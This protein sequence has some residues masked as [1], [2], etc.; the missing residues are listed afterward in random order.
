MVLMQD[1]DN[2]LMR[3]GKNVVKA[4]GAVIDGVE[5]LV[6]ETA[7]QIEQSVA[8]VRESIIKRYPTLFLLAVTFGATATVTG[9]EQ[10]LIQYELLAQHPTVILTLG[11]AIL[12]VTGRLYK[13]FG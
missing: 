1:N 5:Y 10:L 9:M 11:I 7:T 8:P 12:I 13:K 4:T 6:D 2:G 3:A